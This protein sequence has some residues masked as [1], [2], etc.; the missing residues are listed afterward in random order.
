MAKLVV[1]TP[2]GKSSEVPLDKERISVGRHPD[3]QIHL[4]DSSVSGKHAVIITIAGSSFIEDLNS[5]NGTLVNGHRI[6]KHPLN[7][8]ESITIGHCKLDYHGDDDS[9]E[10]F[11]R[12]MVISASQMKALK[13]PPPPDTDKL[14]AAAPAPGELTGVLQVLEGPFKG[15]ELKLT[16]ALNNLGRP[17]ELAAISRRADGYYIVHIGDISPSAKRVQL[18]GKPITAQP[19]KLKAG[20]TVELLGSK[21]RFNL[22]KA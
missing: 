16:R 19:Q 4:N 13:M 15:R 5:T 3:N 8:G 12:T 9:Q 1:T 11:E 17:P 2:D 21:M 18:N 6:K 10:E 14:M 7:S 20:D 22:V